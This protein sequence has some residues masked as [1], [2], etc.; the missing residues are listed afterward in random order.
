[1]SIDPDE[2]D[3]GNDDAVSAAEERSVGDDGFRRLVE[4]LHT[5]HR[6]DFRQY[7][8]PSLVRRI[9]RRMSQVHVETF[10]SYA[11]YLDHHQDEH[12]AL[13]N[14]ILINVT[15]FFRDPDA[16]R[17]LREQVL[18]HIVDDATNRQVRFWSVGC[19]SGEE[20]YSAAILVAEALGHRM[21]DFDVKIYATDIDE[22]ALAA[23]RTGMYRLEAL[24]D[25]PPELLDRYF[26]R[27]GQTYRVRRDIRKWTLFGRHDITTDPPLSH[28]DLL[29]CRNVLIYFDSNLQERILPRFYYA[30]RDRGYLFLGK[31]EAMLTRS[32]RFS[33]IDFKWRIF[34]RSPTSM[35]EPA[36]RGHPFGEEASV[37]QD[38]VRQSRTTDI[39]HL[40]IPFQGIIDALHSAVMVIDP[41]DTIVTWNP[42]AE[43]LFD[44]PAY[45]A[46]GKKFRDLDISYRLEGVRSRV[47]EV[48]TSQT[49]SRLED[50]SFTRR[51]GDIAH[52]TISIAPLYADRR[53]LAGVVVVTDDITEYSYL[54]DEISRISDQSATANEELQSTNEELETTNEELQSTNEELETTNE[55]LQSTNEELETT[56]DELRSINAELA[57]LNTELERRTQELNELDL[58]HKGVLDASDGAIFVLDPQFTV[59]TWN[60]GAARMWSL[61]A[62]D[63]VGRNFSALPI[64]EVTRQAA[65]A[66]RKVAETRLRQSVRGVP[67]TRV[68]GLTGITTLQLFPL[69]GQDGELRGTV[70]TASSE[71]PV[72][73]GQNAG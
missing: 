57:T 38:A 73:A 25:V 41:A 61:R 60:R 63:A 37:A 58:Y 56:V 29:I 20:P 53:R 66:L 22:E 33:P 40:A 27:E 36:L 69:I 50:V 23:A 1:M 10:D 16:W 19:S 51:S 71:E 54:R 62:S 13:F 55:E 45:A 48:K 64:G 11:Q 65:A 68:G 35:G 72:D 47:E 6:F 34:E 8:E 31:S 2:L 21:R 9:L 4:K 67:Y 28:V 49:R 30:I 5:E 17:V 46:V 39:Q 52:V 3:V 24:R 26:Q 12:T 32:R 70:A 42:A 44:I 15:R 14:T 7:K 43:R 18:P 59:T